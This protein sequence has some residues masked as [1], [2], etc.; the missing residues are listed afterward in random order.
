MAAVVMAAVVATVV[1]TV[2]IPPAV[3]VALSRSG[4]GGAGSDDGLVVMAA[5]MAHMHFLYMPFLCCIGKSIFFHNLLICE[6]GNLIQYTTQHVSRTIPLCISP[7]HLPP[8]SPPC[9]STLHLQSASLP[10]QHDSPA[11]C[12]T[13]V[14]P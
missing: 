7:L 13:K 10:C 14:L 1:V 2:I 8:A 5:V 9:I 11:P 12:Q 3:K 4:N 6:C